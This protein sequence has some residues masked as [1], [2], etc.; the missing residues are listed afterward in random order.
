MVPAGAE[1]PSG[2]GANNQ[3]EQPQVPEMPQAQL[4]TGAQASAQAYASVRGLGPSGIGGY[5]RLGPL[6]ALGGRPAL[7]R[8]FLG[9]GH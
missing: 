7:A 9:V 8:V 5:W 3:A 6:A 1:Q 2:N 4:P